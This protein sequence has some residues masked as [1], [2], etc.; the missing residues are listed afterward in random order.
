MAFW[1]TAQRQ[2]DFQFGFS[3]TVG[4]ANYGVSVF[5]YRLGN[6]RPDTRY[7]FTFAVPLGRS[8]N[9]PR[10]STQISHAS[11]GQQVQAG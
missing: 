1:D 4:R 8:E 7:T 9:A 10:A 2:T 5:R 11:G 6:G 3:S